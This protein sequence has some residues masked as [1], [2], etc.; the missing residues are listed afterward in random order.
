M[1]ASPCAQTGT[2][3]SL[4]DEIV[5]AFHDGPR[6]PSTNRARVA[7]GVP[8]GLVVFVTGG[9][10]EAASTVTGEA[11]FGWDIGVWNPTR[12]TTESI[13]PAELTEP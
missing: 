9:T 4:A 2:L 3:A 13:P 10:L 5:A 8:W 6:F 12:V 11:K 7:S 1:T